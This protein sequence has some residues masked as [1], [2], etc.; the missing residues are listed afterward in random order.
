MAELE[1]NSLS[2]ADEVAQARHYTEI[3]GITFV[4]EFTLNYNAVLG[5]NNESD[6]GRLKRMLD[7]LANDVNANQIRDENRYDHHEERLNAQSER[8]DGQSRRIDEWMSR[9]LDEGVRTERL[10]DELRNK[11]ALLEA[12]NNDLVEANDMLTEVIKDLR[13]GH[14]RILLRVMSG[15]QAVDDNLRKM[16]VDLLAMNTTLKVEA[17]AHRHTRAVVERTSNGLADMEVNVYQ[18]MAEFASKL[19]ALTKSIKFK[20]KKNPDVAT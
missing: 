15:E 9:F 1:T 18:F 6:A 16:G 19:E 3:W 4:Y 13:A 2:D 14:D 5:M 17:E 8:M 20:L 7:A 12:T 11:V 10:F